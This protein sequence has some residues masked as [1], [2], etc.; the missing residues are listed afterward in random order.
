[1]RKRSNTTPTASP[2]SS[3]ANALGSAAVRSFSNMSSLSRSHSASSSSSLLE[4]FE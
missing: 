4:K 3:P 2:T 1:M